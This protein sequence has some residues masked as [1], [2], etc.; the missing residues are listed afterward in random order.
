MSICFPFFVRDF[1]SIVIAAAVAAIASSTNLNVRSLD[2]LERS[3]DTHLPGLSHDKE[4]REIESVVF[5]PRLS[6]IKN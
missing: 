2:N 3:P 4:H 5:K 1:L 6:H